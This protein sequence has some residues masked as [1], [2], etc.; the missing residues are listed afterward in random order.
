MS[1]IE[2][3]A[4]GKTRVAADGTTVAEML[5]TLGLAPAQVL[6]ERNGEPLDRGLF[7]GTKLCAG[8]RIEVA[9]MVGGG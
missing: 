3:V 8:D 1:G 9:Q 5:H 7:A 2:Y 6:V 4:N